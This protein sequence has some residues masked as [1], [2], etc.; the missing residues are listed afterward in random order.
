M[1]KIIICDLDE[2][3]LQTWDKKVSKRNREAIAKASA[4]GVK[5]VIGTGRPYTTVQGTLEELGLK[6][7]PEEYVVSLNGGL[8]T[9]NAGN[10]M[11][12]YQGITYSEADALFRRAMNYDVGLHLYTKD[13]VYVWRMDSF[14]EREFLNGRMNV[15]ER[16]DDSLDF[17][18][19]EEIVKVLFTRPDYDFLRRIERE[20]A[21]ITGDMDV[22]YSSNRY[23]EFNRKGVNKGEGLIR[24]ANMLGVDRKDTIAIGDN[25][26]DLSMIKAAG[27]GA[28]VANS[29]K[30]ILPDCDVISEA[31]CDHD[32]VA[33]IIEKYVLK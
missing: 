28:G 3:L 31:D 13:Q 19:D 6:D 33:E 22:S 27:L 1:Y 10:R 2:T 8:I 17:L 26:N 20:I 30:G 21:D 16:T 14:G 32:A 23:I 9:E 25:F 29:A 18:K 24:L 5:F 15:I 7:K 11:L 12:Y 4:L